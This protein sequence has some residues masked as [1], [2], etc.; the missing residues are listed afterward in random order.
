MNAIRRG[1]Y[2]LERGYI[3]GVAPEGTRSGHGRL[4]RGRG[5]AVLLAIKSGAPLL[6]I[7]WYGAEDYRAH[8]K[9]FRRVDFR[10]LVGSPFSLRTAGARLRRAERQRIADEIMYQVAAL[11]PP[12]YRG[13]YANL[14]AA[15]EEYLCFTP[16]AK[17]NLLDASEPTRPTLPSQQ[18][19]GEGSP[20]PS[21]KV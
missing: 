7:A 2:A 15:T 8:W 12:A 14:D 5:G 1:L 9:R 11:L 20:S 4:Q 17:S 16:P 13:H 19:G 10:I 6:P 21:Q 3:V 18:P